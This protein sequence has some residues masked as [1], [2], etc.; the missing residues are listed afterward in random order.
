MPES[1]QNKPHFYI[2]LKLNIFLENHNDASC[3]FYCLQLVSSCIIQANYF[4]IITIWNS[5]IDEFL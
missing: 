1:K 5:R 2:N 3:V 4:L